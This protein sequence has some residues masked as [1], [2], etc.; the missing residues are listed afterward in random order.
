MYKV[1]SGIFTSYKIERD[2]LN[3]KVHYT[4]E[5]GEEAIAF[6]SKRGEWNIQSAKER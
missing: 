3:G 2:F 1:K 4:S 6:E 5:N